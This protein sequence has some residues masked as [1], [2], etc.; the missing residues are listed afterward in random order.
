MIPLE[1]PFRLATPDDASALADLV[2]FAGEG[3][4]HHLWTQ[5]A[6]ADQDP[7]EIGRSRQAARAREG[8]IVVADCGQGAI[9][10]LTG[11]AIGAQPMPIG[12]DM[13]GLLR[14]LQ[15]LENLV[16]KSW[17]VNVLA[18]YPRYRGM[19]YG[20]QLLGLAER[21][22]TGAN[23]D[24]MSIIVACDNAGARRLYERLG[25]REVARRACIRDGWQTE[26]KA[27]VLLTKKLGRA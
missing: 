14:P 4:P 10:S 25:Y 3:L 6:Q 19:G 9:A 16:L 7:W 24:E 12:V 17:Y 22:A 21:I 11:Y 26:T 1:Y 13:P 20:T 15:E 5:L 8:Q 2:D 27:W 23:L 18:C